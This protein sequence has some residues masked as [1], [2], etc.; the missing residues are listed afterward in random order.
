MT[1]IMIMKKREEKEEEEKSLSSRNKRAFSQL[2]NL[3][4]ISF[5]ASIQELDFQGEERRGGGKERDSGGPSHLFLLPFWPAEGPDTMVPL[6]Q[7][8]SVSE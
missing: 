5:K 7:A 1:V 2:L 4:T 3:T 8:Q 6:S